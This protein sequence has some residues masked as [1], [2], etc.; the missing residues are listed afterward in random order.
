MNPSDFGEIILSNQIKLD[1]E[2]VNRYIVEKGIRS[3]IIDSTLDNKVN[4]VRIQ[5]AIDL[6]W[7]D[8]YISNDVFKREI[9]KSTIYFMGGERILLKKVISAKAYTPIAVNSSL[10]NHFVTMDIETIKV[11]NII[12][13]YLI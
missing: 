4:K 9:G 1:G 8:T 12:T 5:G 13:P 11:N 7:T 6:S 2:L 3:Y 10:N